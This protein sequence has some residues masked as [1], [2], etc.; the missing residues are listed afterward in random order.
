MKQP[1]FF[2]WLNYMRLEVK[3]DHHHL[4]VATIIIILIA[5]T[6]YLGFWLAV[7]MHQLLEWIG[8]HCCDRGQHY[9]SLVAFVHKG[10]D[11]PI[12]QTKY[13]SCSLPMSD[14]LWTKTFQ[15]FPSLL[16]IFC[17]ISYMSTR[18]RHNWK[19]DRTWPINSTKESLEHVWYR[20]GDSFMGRR[21]YLAGGM[22]ATLVLNAQEVCLI[23]WSCGR[24][25]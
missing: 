23:V 21:F 16:M 22:C 7:C 2:S 9:T 11:F 5:D 24:L 8:N 25:G 19:I 17:V 18:A 15:Q 20:L 1:C 3:Q 12:H 4:N 6:Y 10:A 14:S 13:A